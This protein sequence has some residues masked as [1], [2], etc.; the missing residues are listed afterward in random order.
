MLLLIV[1][2]SGCAAPAPPTATPS[3]FL[4][5]LPPEVKTRFAET[6]A[7]PTLTPEPSATP[8]LTPSATIPL[9][10]YD[11]PE[12]LLLDECYPSV[13]VGTPIPWWFSPCAD[14]STS[15]DG[16][17]MAYAI[18]PDN[19]GRNLV[20]L[21]LDTGEPIYRTETFGVH[22]FEFL[23]NGKL[24]LG[25]GHCEG[26]GVSLLDPATL[27][28]THL[29]SEGVYHW[30]PKRNAVSVNFAP[31][32]GFEES[33]WGF[34]AS[35][36]FLFLP[37]EDRWQIDNHLLWTP[38]GSHLLF[39]HRDMIRTEGDR[40]DRF[41]N[42]R[43]IIRVNAS[44]GEVT[45]LAG[46]PTYDFH[47]CEGR[48]S[49]CDRWF[50]DWILVRR[51]PYQPQEFEYGLEWTYELNCL[52]YGIDCEGEPGLFALN[53]RTGEMVPWDEVSLPT[54]NKD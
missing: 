42:G 1:L 10:T 36:D 11:L 50:G 38:D 25:K 41:P 53:W 15:V 29:G 4:T 5:P 17:Y 3:P 7:A 8:S 49:G 52:S 13:N 47:L 48:D 46:D 24:L 35:E 54:P 37:E 40:A 14:F 32:Y 21:D 9:P 2:A 16:R 23:P 30:N 51:Y 27:E 43:Q 34:N 44:T 12:E 19:C 31:F 39:Q 28:F 26:G 18:D 45:I 33:V 20:I 22:K 6:Q